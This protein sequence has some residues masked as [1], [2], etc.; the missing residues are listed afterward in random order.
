ML[1]RIKLCRDTNYCNVIFGHISETDF[2]M[3]G[4]DTISNKTTQL[5]KYHQFDFCFAFFSLKFKHPKEFYMF[6][7]KVILI[8]QRK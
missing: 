1:D 2:H 8:K 6:Q 7:T 3:L 4:S 5:R